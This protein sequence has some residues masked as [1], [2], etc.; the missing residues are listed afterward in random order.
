MILCHA[1][2]AVVTNVGATFAA[3]AAKALIEMPSSY[4]AANEVLTL[5]SVAHWR[6][7]VRS[8]LLKEKRNKKEK[9]VSNYRLV[10]IHL[11]T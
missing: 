9:D 1:V 8:R 4:S 2:S 5:T 11:Y 3:R 7:G 6:K 10:I